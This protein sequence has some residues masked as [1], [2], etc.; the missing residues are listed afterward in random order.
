MKGSE[1]CHCSYMTCSSRGLE[2][3]LSLQNKYW[4]L[5]FGFL[6]NVQSEFTDHVLELPVGCIFSDQMNSFDQ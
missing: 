4:Y 1:I 5:V 3:Q 6:H 2:F